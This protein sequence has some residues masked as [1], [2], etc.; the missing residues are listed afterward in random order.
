[1][2]GPEP[3]EDAQHRAEVDQRDE[4]GDVRSWP[5]KPGQV[6]AER[7]HDDQRAERPG[8]AALSQP[9][10]YLVRRPLDVVG[11]RC[12]LPGDPQPQLIEFRRLIPQ[13][14]RLVNRGDVDRP[15]LPLAKVSP[16]P[17]KYQAGDLVHVG[18][19]SGGW[20]AH[21]RRVAGGSG[22]VSGR[23]VGAAVGLR[24]RPRKRRPRIGWLSGPA[25]VIVAGH[26]GKVTPPGLRA[27]M[28]ASR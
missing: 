11:G 16:D 19:Q 2:L 23:L 17:V 18:G 25:D 1:M 27:C 5:A 22:L 4:P 8:T 14:D 6:P 28:I 9:L 20:L 10:G 7:E 15:V 12:P 3:E 26:A 24:V 21:D 13:R